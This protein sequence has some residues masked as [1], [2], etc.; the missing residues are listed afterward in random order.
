MSSSS[1][2]VVMP[3]FTSHK[4][5]A[6]RRL[7]QA[8]AD[9]GLDLLPDDHRLHADRRI[10]LAGLL[11]EFL[12]RLLAADDLDQRQQIDRVERVPDH[13]ALG[14]LHRR[15]HVGRLDAR[16]RGAD[17]RVLRRM[18]IDLGQHAVLEVEPLRHAFLDEVGAVD[19]L[20]DGL[21]VADRALPR[22]PLGQH[23]LVGAPRA[24]HHFADLARGFRIGIED[25]HVDAVQHEARDPP[26]ADD[27][28]ADRSGLAD[29][30][31]ADAPLLCL[32]VSGSVS[33]T[34]SPA[35]MTAGS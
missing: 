5:L 14:P 30:A 23:L 8:V 13:Q 7:E 34:R 20:G 27:A 31:H 9:E 11:D 15:L 21:G 26:R 16:R 1:S 29:D 3:S 6:P 12:G 17:Q 19:R 22:Q 32:A 2:T 10:D 24:L 25:R 35:R 4:R 18:R 33:A 28:A